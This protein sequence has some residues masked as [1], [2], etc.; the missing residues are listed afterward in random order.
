MRFPIDVLRAQPGQNVRLDDIDT[1]GT[2]G[3]D[4]DR[5]A[6]EARTVELNTRLEELQEVLWAQ[7]TNRLLVVLQAMDA[8]GKDGTIRHVFDGV[9]PSGVRVASFKKPSE[10]E[11]THDYLWRIHAEVPGDGE[12]VIFNR[13]HYEDVLVVRVLGLVE[14]ERLHRRYRHIRDFEQLLIDEGTTIIK[15]ML[16]ISKQEQRERLQE[17]LDRPD[18]HWKFDPGDLAM[19]VRWD[20]FMGAFEYAIEQTSTE[21]APWFVVP[22]D[23]KWYRDLAISEILVQTLETMEID[24]PAPPDLDGITIDD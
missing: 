14:D 22:A 12:I 9:N 19:R 21:D 2:P 16:H 6:A 4:E 18:K 17:R 23:R 3:W 10:V 24:Y 5:E 8:G 1:S 15:I 13:S 11:R 7:G 20:D